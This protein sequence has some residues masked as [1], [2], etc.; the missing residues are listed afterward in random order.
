MSELW[1]TLL[2]SK[3]WSSYAC[4]YISPCIQLCLTIN[5]FHPYASFLLLSALLPHL[6]LETF[7]TCSAPS[8]APVSWWAHSQYITKW[9]NVISVISWIINKLI[10]PLM[11]ICIKSHYKKWL[12]YRPKGRT[13][14]IIMFIFII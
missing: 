13:E 5:T 2:T 1:L 8:T 9:L 7:L 14:C 4:L 11:F 12:E 3:R 10:L 6:L